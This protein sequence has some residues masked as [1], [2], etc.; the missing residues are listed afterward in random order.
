MRHG[1]SI[2]I[3]QALCITGLVA[4]LAGAAPF[5]ATARAAGGYIDPNN[6]PPRVTDPKAPDIRYQKRGSR[7]LHRGDEP[8]ETNWTVNREMSRACRHGTFKQRA[9]RRYVALL[10][11]KIYGAALGG[12]GSLV[13]EAGLSK[14]DVLYVFA[15]QGTTACRVY[16]RGQD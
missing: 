8:I 2:R 10:G 11:K 9:D 12:H 4:S 1:N 14:I 7:V 5:S 13:D 15:G 6:P 3:M 16:H